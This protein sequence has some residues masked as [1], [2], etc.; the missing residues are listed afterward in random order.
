MMKHNDLIT[1]SEL[2][3]PIKTTEAEKWVRSLLERYHDTEDKKR[4]LILK[5]GIVKKVVDELIPLSRYSK[6]EY[7]QS[8]IYLKYY[9]DSRQSFDAEFIDKNNNVI[10]RVEVTMAISGQNRRIQDEHFIKYS[11]TPLF[12]TLKSSG[13][14]GD[15]VLNEHEL[16]CID[17]ETIIKIQSDLLQSAYDKKQCN[18]TKYPDT[19][20]LIGLDIPVHMK[21]EFHQIINTFK[22]EIN[23]F[24]A[25]KCVSICGLHYSCLQ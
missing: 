25:I 4:Y 6:H 1:E 7:N 16:S 10:E 17:Q 3:K 9:P 13:K 5:N 14:V 23:T 19:T 21:S 15:R 20:L 8:S 24:K 12:K 18:I 2:R 22:P 11:H